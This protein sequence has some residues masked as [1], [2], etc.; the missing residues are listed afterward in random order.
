MEGL[1][2]GALGSSDEGEQAIEQESNSDEED[3]ELARLLESAS[4]MVGNLPQATGGKGKKRR[5]SAQE[6]GDEE[7]YF[8]D[9]FFGSRGALYPSCQP[10]ECSSP[11]ICLIAVMLGLHSP[12]LSPLVHRLVR[13]PCLRRL[14]LRRMQALHSTTA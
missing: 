1:N 13:L 8:Y 4:E 11:H 10:C 7:E 3:A 6:E 2:P 5:L 9:D 14:C 12:I